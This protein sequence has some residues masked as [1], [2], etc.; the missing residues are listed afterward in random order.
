MKNVKM[1]TLA[2]M[3]LAVVGFSLNAAADPKWN[4][5]EVMKAAQGKDAL[6]SKVKG[7][8]AT[9]EEKKMLVE[10]YTALCQNT[11]KKGDKDAWEKRCKE[12]VRR[13]RWKGPVFQ[14]SA[15]TR[16]G[17]EQLV[18]TIYQH[19]AAMQ[20]HHEEADVRFDGSALPMGTELL[21]RAGLAYDDDLTGLIKPKKAPAKKAAAK[22][23]AAKKVAAK[24]VPAKK[25]PAKKAPA[26]KAAAKKVVAKKVVAT[27]VPAQKVAAKKAPAKKAPAKKAPAKKAPAKKTVARKTSSRA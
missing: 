6:L 20:E 10:V 14:I 9:D 26:K 1:F 15:L 23:A 11:P 2:A 12:I 19:V 17:C 27:K 8:K 25:A 18:Q 3:F 24:K 21:A 4:I 5:K 16:E 13:L 7:G 22:K